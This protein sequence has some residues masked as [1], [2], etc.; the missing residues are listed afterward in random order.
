MD[1]TETMTAI[2]DFMR[3]ERNTCFVCGPGNP[4]GL[5]LRFER[6]ASG[7]AAEFTLGEWVQGWH[8]VVHGGVLTS[9]L[10]EA[11]AYTLFMDGHEGLTAR[12]EARFRKPVRALDQLR[13]EARIIR[14][15]GRIADIEAKLLRGSEV[16]AEGS[17]RFVVV[18][19][20]SVDSIA[21][22]HLHLS[23]SAGSCTV[24]ADAGAGEEGR[25]GGVT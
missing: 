6:E 17:S 15:R 1:K 21:A 18:G 4:H 19:A 12:I 25:S 11:M 22:G 14:R 7:V 10:D 20:L 16:V 3:S 23:N 9:V 24:K 5:R 8:G 13:A 2:L